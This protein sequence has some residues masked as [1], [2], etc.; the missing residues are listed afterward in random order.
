MRIIERMTFA[1]GKSWAPPSVL[2]A[3]ATIVLSSCGGSASDS[4]TRRL[5]EYRARL[6]EIGHAVEQLQEDLS[7]LEASVTDVRTAIDDFDGRKWAASLEEVDEALSKAEDDF[8]EV[9]AAADDV[10]SRV[11][12]SAEGASATVASRE[13]HALPRSPES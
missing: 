4:Q 1:Q 13:R 7:E 12:T 11:R 6:D 10:E 2:L 9:Q 5:A 8:D 3:A